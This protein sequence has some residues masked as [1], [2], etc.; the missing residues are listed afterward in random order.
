MSRTEYILL[1]QMRTIPWIFVTDDNSRWNF[2][3]VTILYKES[4]YNFYLKIFRFTFAEIKQAQ[5]TAI[6]QEN[7]EMFAGHRLIPFK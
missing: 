3:N 4:F 7:I 2:I 5:R 1:M 6:L